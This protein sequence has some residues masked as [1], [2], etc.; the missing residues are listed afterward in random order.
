ML[1]GFAV[2][3]I[4]KAVWISQGNQIVEDGKYKGIPGVNQHNLVELS[5]A[6][7]LALSDKVKEL[8]SR[9]SIY[10]TSIG[11]YP[12]A[13]SWGIT[14]IRKRIDGSTS[15]PSFWR[16]PSDYVLLERFIQK[17]KTEL[18]RKSEKP[19]KQIRLA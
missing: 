16:I 19:P 18:H 1:R 14:K 9:L 7:G 3:C 11:R 4:L 8:L 12:I 10:T 2:E 6:I 13:K 15:R 5:K 17:L